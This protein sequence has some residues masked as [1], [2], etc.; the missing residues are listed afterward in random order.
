[1]NY[2]H[3]QIPDALTRTIKYN[4]VGYFEISFKILRVFVYDY[5]SH[6]IFFKTHL[7]KPRTSQTH[8]F[9]DL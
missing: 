1:M 9:S 7:H 8:E 2:C 4:V 3:T 6:H 5:Y